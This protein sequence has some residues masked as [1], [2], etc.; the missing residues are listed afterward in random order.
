MKRYI[1]QAIAVIGLF[2]LV[3]CQKKDSKLNPI[4][5]VT[6]SKN[7]S[8]NLADANIWFEYTLDFSSSESQEVMNIQGRAESFCIGW[9]VAVEGIDKHEFYCK[10]EKVNANPLQFRM[11]G[12][13]TPAP[14]HKEPGTQGTLIHL[15]PP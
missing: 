8:S 6:Y 3:T 15:Y 2:V 4:P 9:L 1:L 14:I 7:F 12:Y 10:W 11:T 5:D 13:L